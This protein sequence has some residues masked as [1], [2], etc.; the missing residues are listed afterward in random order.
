MEDPEERQTVTRP[1]S[2]TCGSTAACH[3]QFDTTEMQYINLD[4]RIFFRDA[5]R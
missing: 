2:N 4:K 3:E 5:M 1:K